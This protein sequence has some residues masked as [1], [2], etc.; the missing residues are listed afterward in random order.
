MIP[1]T[2]LLPVFVILTTFFCVAQEENK[3]IAKNYCTE[4]GR[5]DLLIDNDEVAGA[6]YLI[7]KNALG[8]VWGRL[9]G[10]VM[11][12]RWHDADGKGDIIITFESDFSFFT[13]DYRSDDE[14]EK[15]YKDSWHGSLRP[16]KASQFTAKGK[17][18]KCE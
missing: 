16:N 18:F 12:G 17:T 15:W 9:K 4:I 5:F 8:G 6:Y 2:F 13:A 14:P 1:R 7:H 3:L 11:T 10:N